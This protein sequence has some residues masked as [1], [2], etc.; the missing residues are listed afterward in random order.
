M[1]KL[2]PR[3]QKAGMGAGGAALVTALLMATVPAHEGK[4]NDPY[5]DIVK[6][7]TVCYGH[8][9]A[10]IQNKR[11]TDAECLA[12][13][14]DDLVKHAEPVLACTPQIKDK[15]YIT[16]AAVSLAFNIGTGAYCKSTAAKRFRSGDFKGG[17]AAIELWNK[18]GGKVV[19]GLAKRRADERA[20][21]E[22]GL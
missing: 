9:G 12:L 4:R 16:A 6:V 10:D 20:M 5:L 15:P 11:Y 17:C 22:R 19:K 13:L 18:A 14:E 8:T 2:S 21:C 1:S 3:L 7:R